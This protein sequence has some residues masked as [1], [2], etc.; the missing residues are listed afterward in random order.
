VTVVEEIAT[1]LAGVQ[2]PAGVQTLIVAVDGCGGAGKSTF[3]ARLGERLDAPVVSTDEF[4][5]WSHPLDWYPRV[6]SE[7]LMPL[8]DGR[9]ATYRRSEWGGGESVE[10]TVPPVPIL[11]LEGVSSSRRAFDEYLAFRIWVETDR[12]E[13]LRRGLERD[14]EQLRDQWLEWMASEDTYVADE[15]PQDRADIVIRGDA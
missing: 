9:A 7:L 4:A 2:A 3:A 6:I 12:A 10:V 5:S 11:V 15:H 14:G 13:R 8:A 1:A